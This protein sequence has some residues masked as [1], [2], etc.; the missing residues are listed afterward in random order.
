[1]F[2]K[3]TRVF[4]QKRTLEA[5]MKDIYYCSSKVEEY[6]NP[7]GRLII[8]TTYSN[9]L[10]KKEIHDEEKGKRIVF[11]AR[12]GHKIETHIVDEVSIN[13]ISKKVNIHNEI[14]D[15]F[16]SLITNDLNFAHNE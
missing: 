1:M 6:I 16:E 4:S 12:I 14:V 8:K 5:L 9:G 10:V 11:S 3:S 7:N 2:K 15:M 13:C